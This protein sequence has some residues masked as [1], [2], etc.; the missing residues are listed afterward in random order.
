MQDKHVI[1]AP[2]PRQ[3]EAK[4]RITTG[5]PRAA[6]AWIRSGKLVHI[7][8]MNFKDWLRHIEALARLAQTGG[9]K[10]AMQREDIA[11]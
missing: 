5:D 3:Q 11:A 7:V 2:G 8:P 9:T 6:L 4:E 1:L 10:N